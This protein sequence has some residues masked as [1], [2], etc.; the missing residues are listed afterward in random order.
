MQPQEPNHQTVQPTSTPTTSTSGDQ[1]DDSHHDTLPHQMYYSRPHAPAH[2]VIPPHV[3]EKHEQSKRRYP[4]LNLSEGE[5]VITD[6]A[7]HPI[8]LIRIWFFVAVGI[9]AVIGSIFLFSAGNGESG[10]LLSMGLSP[11]ILA[12]ISITTILV[13]L[14]M[15]Y[16]ATFVYTANHMYLTNESIIQNIQI[17][18]FAKRQQTVSLSNVED[19]SYAKHGI[20]STILDYGEVRLSTEG[21]ETTYQ[22]TYANHPEKEVTLLN[23]A[24]EAFKHGRPID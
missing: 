12:I 14:A 9:A 19:A 10:G 11:T 16:L 5:Y 1:V 17:T 13:A 15:G 18:P 24:V 22:F 2:P 23:N 4:H 21:E 20:L 8:G 7:R 6:V 3:Q